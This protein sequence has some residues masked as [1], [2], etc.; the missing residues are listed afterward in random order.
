MVAEHIQKEDFSKS[1]LVKRAWRKDV[2]GPC[3]YNLCSVNVN[4]SIL[5]KYRTILNHSQ[6][7]NYQN[8]FTSYFS[9][10]RTYAV[11]KVSFLLNTFSL[12]HRCPHP[13]VQLHSKTYKLQQTF[14]LTP[15]KQAF[16]RAS[17]VLLARI[18]EDYHEAN[19]RSVVVVGGE[20]ARLD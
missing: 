11:V 7:K 16:I 5:L 12:K 1:R 8:F 19:Q 13:G 9:S 15:T 2:N 18:S 6:N 17:R 14:G 20:D 4:L 3:I 10:V